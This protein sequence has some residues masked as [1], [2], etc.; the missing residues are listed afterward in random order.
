VA[1]HAVAFADGGDAFAHFHHIGGGLVPKQVRQKLVRPLYRI[2][3]VDLRPTYPA[4]QNLD[5]NLAEAQ[6]RRFDLLH[7]QGLAGLDQDGGSKFHVG[8]PYSK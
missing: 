5:Q 3:L 7:N 6:G 1:H 4:A 8:L 2:D